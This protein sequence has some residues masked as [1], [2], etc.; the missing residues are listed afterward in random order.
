LEADLATIDYGMGEQNFRCTARTLLI[1]E[2]EFHSDPYER[3]TGDLIA[4]VFG[5]HVVTEDSLGLSFDAEGNIDAIVI[6]YTSDNWGAELR[7]LWAM[8]KTQGE[9]D[10]KHGE[11][12]EPVPSFKEWSRQ[13]LECEID[14]KQLSN[15]IVE[16]LDRGLFRAGAAAS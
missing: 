13:I 14:I 6:D 15:A 5:K 1:Y 7:A 10:A 16:E 8:L 11:N 4:D 9:I 12:K 2:Q 3:V